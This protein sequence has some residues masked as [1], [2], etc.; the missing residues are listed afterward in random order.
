VNGTFAEDVAYGG[1]PEEASNRALVQCYGNVTKWAM[2]VDAPKQPVSR[3]RIPSATLSGRHLPSP[4]PS[5][6]SPAG[7]ALDATMST[8]LRP[9][10][11]VTVSSLSQAL[12]SMPR[13]LKE[14]VAPSSHFHN[15][16]PLDGLGHV[17]VGAVLSASAVVLDV[18]L[19]LVPVVVVAWRRQ[20][21]LTILQQRLRFRLAAVTVMNQSRH[22]E[23]DGRITKLE[24]EIGRLQEQ[25]SAKEL[26]LFRTSAQLKMAEDEIRDMKEKVCALRC[27]HVSVSRPAVDSGCCVYARAWVWYQAM[28]FAAKQH[29]SHIGSID[30]HLRVL[31][32]EQQK[33]R[34][35]RDDAVARV[36]SHVTRRG[37]DEWTGGGGGE[38][39]ISG[40][41]LT[42]RL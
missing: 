29:E 18:T 22:T 39:G 21:A 40:T 5:S 7:S 20:Q 26:A 15:C 36:V 14:L 19:T 12:E 35:E 17:E 9:T 2:S 27:A 8:P 6:P 23:K 13:S 4:L 34:L 24:Q 30:S 38:E 42:P 25:L 11:R 1:L 16:D 32:E 37:V 10:G 41:R 3:P 33:L 31:V 28:A